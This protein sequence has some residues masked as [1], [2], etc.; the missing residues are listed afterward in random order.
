M[1]GPNPRLLG[2]GGVSHS[3]QTLGSLG[4]GSKQTRLDRRSSTATKAGCRHYSTFVDNSN[5]TCFII[6][7]R[8][9]RTS[10][11]MHCGRAEDVGDFHPRGAV[12]C[13][14][15]AL[16]LV[17]QWFRFCP[18]VPGITIGSSCRF[19]AGEVGAWRTVRSHREVVEVELTF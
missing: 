3:A 5:T 1:L 14:S 15:R 9:L 11:T 2:E 13:Q 16:V 10:C 7:Y 19:G 12:S 8:T 18:K 4:S 17:S 6:H